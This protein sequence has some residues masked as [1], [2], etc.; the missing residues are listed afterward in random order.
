MEISTDGET[1]EEIPIGP[2]TLTG[3][4]LRLHD[5]AKLRDFIKGVHLMDH[6]LRAAR[7]NTLPR[8]AFAAT[9][10]EVRF[11]VDAWPIFCAWCEKEPRILYDPGSV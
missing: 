11:G 3:H 7:D 2:R 8:L 6:T 10:S 5:L 1:W 9:G 4:M